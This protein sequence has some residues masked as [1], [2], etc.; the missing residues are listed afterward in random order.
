MSVV[1]P[2]LLRV[3]APTATAMLQRVAQ[4]LVL[5]TLSV[6]ASPEDRPGLVAAF[7]IVGALGVLSDSGAANYLLVHQSTQTTVTSLA[8]LQLLMG[9]LGSVTSVVFAFAV[10]SANP[11]A[12][13]AAIAA[14]QTLESSARVART[15][16]LIERREHR[17]AALDGTTSLSKVVLVGLCFA[18]GELFWLY[19]LPVAPALLLVSLLGWRL[20]VQAK[21]ATAD[22]SYKQVLLYGA[23][24]AASALYSQSPLLVAGMVLP[25]SDVAT[26]TLCY[27]I[28]QPMELIPATV[29]HQLLPQLRQGAPKG[30]VVYSGFFI[31]G[32]AFTSLAILCL[33]FIETLFETQISPAAPYLILAAVMPVKFGNYALTALLL[34][35]GEVKRK[36]AI[37]SSVG[38]L[39]TCIAGVAS[40]AGSSTLISAVTLLSELILLTLM[41]HALRQ[42]PGGSET[43]AHSHRVSRPN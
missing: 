36:L 30:S 3:S 20:Q 10:F 5:L 41:C 31:L 16:L 37:S 13:V 40:M 18:G 33:P 17:Y 2:R 42:A 4:L 38:V 23:N 6:V 12:I 1:A 34:A 25:V 11:I 35:A 7:G 21:E 39:T 15:P 19:L 26:L 43:N 14:S 27:R 8:K 24:G 28:I 29:A 32:V 9:T 22:V